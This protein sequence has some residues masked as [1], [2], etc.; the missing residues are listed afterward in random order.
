MCRAPPTMDRVS[1]PAPPSL[2]R[3]PREAIAHVRPGHTLMVGGFGLVGAPL[4]LIEALR[5][6]PGGRDLT[7]I[8]NNLGEPG[9]GLGRVLLD[10]GVRKAIGSFFTSNP[11][12]VRWHA[13]GRLEVEL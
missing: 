6:H 7:I 11:D 3:D 13:E 10:G 12:V 4:T 9:R 1:T 2:L 5:G 8:S